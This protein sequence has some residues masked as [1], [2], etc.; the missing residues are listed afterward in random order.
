M[1]KITYRYVGILFISLIY[2]FIYFLITTKHGLLQD[3]TSYYEQYSLAN[4]N[5]SEAIHD[6]L[7]ILQMEDRDFATVS[8]S[9]LNGIAFIYFGTLS[10]LPFN[11]FVFMNI[12]ILSIAAF[13]LIR[14]ISNLNLWN[15]FF[16]LLS[17]PM[18]VNLHFTWRQFAAQLIVLYFAAS[19]YKHKRLSFLLCS[20]L[21]HPTALLSIPE[22]HLLLSRFKNLQR[23]ILIIASCLVGYVIAFYSTVSFK[24]VN[25]NALEYT[26]VS[27][28]IL[29][30]L[31]YLYP[32][33]AKGTKGIQSIIMFMPMLFTYMAFSNSLVG[34]SRI[35]TLGSFMSMT[36]SLSESP[37]YSRYY[38][39][40]GSASFILYILFIRK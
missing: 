25:E 23:I 6:L 1:R 40:I 24:I 15:I 19:S 4:L 32:L 35:I 3:P 10:L 2:A 38:G 11:I 29:L 17:L 14:K 13:G 8:F 12:Y 27:L 18:I 34:I 16:I 39:I 26:K 33:L 9:R 7:T 28:W 22:K 37:R 31:L 30:L 5:I 20:L 36:I 21:I